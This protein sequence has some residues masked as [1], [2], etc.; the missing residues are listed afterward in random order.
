MLCI[1]LGIPGVG[2][3]T[4]LRSVAKKISVKRLNFGDY[5]FNE[6]KRA[7][8]VNDRDDMRKLPRETQ[9]EL[10]EKAAHE[11]HMHSRGQNVIVDT[12]SSIKTPMGYM[13]GLPENVLRALDPE[14]IILLEYDPKLIHKRRLG[15][16]SRNR[17]EDS[18]EAI[19]EHQLINRCFASIYAYLTHSTLLI[20]QNVEGKPEEAAEK[21]AEVFK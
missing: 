2:K 13:P 15:D 4:V 9:L 5:M 8:L 19:E 11:I 14:V 3:T 10:Q 20:V 21:I 7:G 18:I 16:P 17:D 1:L 12:H 6:A